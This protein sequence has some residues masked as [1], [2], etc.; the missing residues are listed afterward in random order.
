MKSSLHT[1][2]IPKVLGNMV[3]KEKGDGAQAATV[4]ISSDLVTSL[5]SPAGGVQTS[6]TTIWHHLAGRRFHSAEF[7]SKYKA[8][9]TLFE[10]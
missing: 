2:Q 6:V 10:H 4:R 5:L 9:R 1:R 8:I 3:V 7:A